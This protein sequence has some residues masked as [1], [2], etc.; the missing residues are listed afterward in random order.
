MSID[1]LRAAVEADGRAR[2]SAILETAQERADQILAEAQSRGTGR[3]DEALR[4][5]ERRLRPE[6]NRRVAALRRDARKRALEARDALLDRVFEAAVE[7]LPEA[8]EEPEARS[9]LAARAIQAL[10]YMPAGSVV[11]TGSSAVAPILETALKDRD[12]VRVGCDP[13]LDV[14]FRAVGGDGSL[15]VDATFAKQ[16]ELDRPVLAIEVLR[17]LN[18]EERNRSTE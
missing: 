9:R 6:E 3:Q 10:G 13:E 18:G 12:A 15:V 5:A 1:A 8:L 17:Q 14:G 2:V 16:L 4:E 11:V 7:A